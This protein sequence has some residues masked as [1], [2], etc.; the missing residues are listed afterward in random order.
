MKD[1]FFD[2]LLN[3]FEKTLTQITEKKSREEILP[4]ITDNTDANHKESLIFKSADEESIRVF[5][6]AEQAKLTKAS[7]QF[8][9]RIMS[10]GVIAPE[11]MEIIINQLLFSDSRYVTLSE[12]KWTIRN[13]LADH[14]EAPQLVF[15]DLV[16][17][18]K[19]DELP[20]H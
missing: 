13:T 5:T 2:M 17:Y 20:S 6:P 8:L 14:L 9:M 10:W 19:E 7:Y 4:E 1:T 3:F 16:L 12:T 15:L 18:R 11:T